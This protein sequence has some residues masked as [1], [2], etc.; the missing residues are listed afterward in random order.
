MTAHFVNVQLANR[1]SGNLV[2][3]LLDQ[4]TASELVTTTEEGEVCNWKEGLELLGG[5]NQSMDM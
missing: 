5:E 3:G 1:K 4:K 2:K